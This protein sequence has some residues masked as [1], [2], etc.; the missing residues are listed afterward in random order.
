MGC[1]G[2]DEKV[3]IPNV[4]KRGNRINEQRDEMSFHQKVEN[5]PY[6]L[7]YEEYMREKEANTKLMRIKGDEVVQGF[8]LD[9]KRIQIRELIDIYNLDEVARLSPDQALRALWEFANHDSYQ[10]VVAEFEGLKERV[11]YL[12]S[13]V[14]ENQIKIKWK[15]NTI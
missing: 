9:Y 11:N 8:S 4:D 1:N 10:E 15:L 13:K 5:T 7:T 2:C 6:A 14:E 12:Y 3:K